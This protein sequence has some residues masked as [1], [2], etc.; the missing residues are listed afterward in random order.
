MAVLEDDVIAQIEAP[1][2]RVDPGAQLRRRAELLIA[3]L[4]DRERLF[5]LQSLFLLRLHR[6]S[7]DFGASEGLRVVETAIAMVTPPGLFDTT[8][9]S[10][11]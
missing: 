4:D 6:A 10:S 11:V 9:N 8:P 3:T 5:E 1:T 2:S 7:D